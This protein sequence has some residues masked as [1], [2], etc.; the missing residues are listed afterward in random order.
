MRVENFFS[1][2]IILLALVAGALMAGLAG[3]IWEPL[4]PPVGV[5]GW[6]LAYLLLAATPGNVLYCPHCRKRTKI[7][8]SV[9]HHCQ[10]AVT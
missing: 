6:V 10:R 1:V 9:C 3:A 4:G 2:R 8:A 5:I 7:G